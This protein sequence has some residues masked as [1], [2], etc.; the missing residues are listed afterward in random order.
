MH[1]EKFSVA[2]MGQILAHV[3]RKRDAGHY[4]NKNI[5]STKTKDNFSPRNTLRL[6]GGKWVS[7]PLVGAKKTLDYWAGMQKRTTGRAL[8]KDAV[9]L[10]SIVVT[11]PD[12]YKDARRK[13][14]CGS[15]S[16]CGCFLESGF[17]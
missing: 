8:R 9:A 6:V 4:G 16:L 15:S 5:D 3:E 13:N 14:R 17:K 12:E 11:L 2:S 7:V 10:A 1:I